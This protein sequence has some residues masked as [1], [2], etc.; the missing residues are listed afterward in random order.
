MSIILTIVMFIVLGLTANSQDSTVV[1]PTDS[2]TIKIYY[3]DLVGKLVEEYYNDTDLVHILSYH[4]DN[5]TIARDAYTD[6]T[7]QNYVGIASN[8]DEN[9]SLRMTIDNDN[10][11]WTPADTTRYPHFRLLNRMKLV[12]DSLL[13]KIYCDAFLNKYL[14][15]NIGDSYYFARNYSQPSF[16][17]G[18]LRDESYKYQPTEFYVSY[19]LYESN[20]KHE[21]AIKLLFDLNGNILG[22]H[23]W[24]NNWTVANRGLEQLD[25]DSCRNFELS[26]NDAVSYVRGFISRNDDTT[27]AYGFLTW[28][29]SGEEASIFNGTW[30]IYVLNPRKVKKK[31]RSKGSSTSERQYY[32]VYI[33]NPW[34]GMFLEQKLMYREIDSMP[35][36]TISCNQLIEEK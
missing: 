13:R 35:G 24:N 10:R 7:R 23:Q 34:T 15:W 26:V 18:W 25:T 14:R 2:S 31:R 27:Q 22:S 8:Y 36:I 20:I 3:F 6:R 11:T 21:R 32:D 5:L 4:K 1:I 17:I 16:S 30:R 29:S 19:D 9:G 12:A 33:F 28:A